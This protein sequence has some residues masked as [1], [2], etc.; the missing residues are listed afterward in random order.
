MNWFS[1]TQ[2]PSHQRFMNRPYPN[3][4][5]RPPRRASLQ[6]RSYSPYQQQEINKPP[7]MTLNQ[8]NNGVQKLQFGLQLFS[9]FIKKK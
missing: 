5:F 6:R 9:A 7:H 3:N 4:R 2:E 1:P 8:L